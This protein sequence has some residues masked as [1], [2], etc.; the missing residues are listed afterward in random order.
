MLK[1]RGSV[2]ANIHRQRSME[3]PTKRAKWDRSFKPGNGIVIDLEED[4][5]EKE[6]EAK[7]AEE[8]HETAQEEEEKEETFEEMHA[9]FVLEWESRQWLGAVYAAGGCMQGRARD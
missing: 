7:E 8:E 2:W 6:I 5:Q 1:L 9:A 4:K 3:P